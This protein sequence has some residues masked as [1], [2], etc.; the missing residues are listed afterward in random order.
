[1]T[2]RQHFSSA[3][4]KTSAR[5]AG[6]DAEHSHVWASGMRLNGDFTAGQL[7]ISVQH[8]H[9]NGTGPT[10]SY[11]NIKVFRPFASFKIDFDGFDP[12]F[13]LKADWIEYD[14]R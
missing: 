12:M 5:A 11:E 2:R 4:K 1:V 7:Q 8:L 10:Y 3:W 14:S 13:R 9:A 6:R